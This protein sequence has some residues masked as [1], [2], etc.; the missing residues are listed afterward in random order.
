M[1]KS[2]KLFFDYFKLGLVAGIGV[3]LLVVILANRENKTDVWFGAQFEQVSTLWLIAVTAG[4]SIVGFWVLT[5]IRGLIK[6]VRS[7]RAQREHERKL[8]Q[9]QALAK[10]LSAQERRIDEK[11]R[12]SIADSDPGR[13]EPS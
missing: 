10:E 5:R 4:A 11:L 13:P 9:Q 7:Q 2:L 8:A 6:S 12:K 1:M 3:F